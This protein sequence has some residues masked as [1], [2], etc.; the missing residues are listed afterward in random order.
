FG[1]NGGLVNVDG[2]IASGAAN[3]F[4]VT[5]SGVAGAAPAVFRFNGGPNHLSNNNAADSNW[6]NGNNALRLAITNS[7]PIRIE[8]NQGA[9]FVAPNVAT[10]ANPLTIRGVF[11]GDPSSGPNGTIHTGITQNAGRFDL[12][13]Q[14]ISTYSGG[15][16]LQDSLRLAQEGAARDIKGNIIIAGT[17]S[18]HPGNVGFFGRSTGTALG[19]AL[20]R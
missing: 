13:N 5:T 9:M 17:A 19:P 16:T 10:L 14:A 3:A 18:G 15:L 11:G 7:G 4:T 8:L 6:T 1:A 2:S 20:H 12:P